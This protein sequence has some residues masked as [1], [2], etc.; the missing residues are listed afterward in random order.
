[1]AEEGKR[2]AIV[3]A[4]TNPNKFGNKAVR[5]YL[6]QDYR[7]FPVTPNAE[8]VEGLKAYPTILD[9]PGDVDIV[10]LYLPPSVG[11]T[12]LGEIAEKG[13]KTLFLNPGAES[14]ELLERATSLGLNAVVAC[15]ILAVGLKP[16]E[17]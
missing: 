3:G 10:S 1:M 15:S 4:S 7:V 6:K 9:I 11:V 16:E 12:I 8:S 2:I 14:D 13:V 5:A 17:V